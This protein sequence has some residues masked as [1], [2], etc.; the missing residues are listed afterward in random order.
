MFLF[1][2][3]RKVKVKLQKKEISF[4]DMVVFF[5]GGGGGA[6]EKNNTGEVVNCLHI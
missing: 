2:I 6:K 1:S 3:P 5:G 4:G